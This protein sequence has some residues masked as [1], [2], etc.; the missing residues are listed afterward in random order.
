MQTKLVGGIVGTAISTMG[1]VISTEQLE[2]IVSIVCSVIGVLIV[3]VTSLIVPLVKW[4]KK[5]KQDGVITKE[6]IQEGKEIITT[7][8]KEVKDAIEKEKEKK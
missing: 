6:E 2:Q 4:Y 8:A 5:S 1:M 7:G 3:I